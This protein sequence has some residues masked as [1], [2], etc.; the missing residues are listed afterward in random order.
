MVDLNLIIQNTVTDWLRDLRP[1]G[2][3]EDAELILDTLT[4]LFQ[5]QEGVVLEAAID[6]DIITGKPCWI[7]GFNSS[8][9]NYYFMF[10]IE[11]I[12]KFGCFR[13]THVD[14]F[15]YVEDGNP[16]SVK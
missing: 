16:E 7:I 2:K 11:H 14:V 15:D 3:I 5:K 1:N 10:T 8:A 12:L 4:I 6:R 9:L 13:C